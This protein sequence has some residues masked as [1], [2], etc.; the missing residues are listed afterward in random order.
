MKVAFATEARHHC[1]LPTV[2]QVYES[3]LPRHCACPAHDS[4]QNAPATNSYV[5]SA[6]KS[7]SL[8]ATR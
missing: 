6:V 4:L 5:A 2:T 1:R 7:S 3:L 8:T